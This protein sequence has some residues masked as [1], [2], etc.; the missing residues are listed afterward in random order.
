MKKVKFGVIDV[1]PKLRDNFV[2]RYFDGGQ[3]K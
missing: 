1:D 3:K 2:F